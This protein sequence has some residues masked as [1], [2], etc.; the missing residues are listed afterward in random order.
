MHQSFLNLR[1][2]KSEQRSVTNKRLLLTE[3]IF[4]S[5]NSWTLKIKHT[6]IGQGNHVIDDMNLSEKET[7][8]K[9]ALSK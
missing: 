1:S 9:T 2:K 7:T 3:E 5:S 6:F 8:F 4:F